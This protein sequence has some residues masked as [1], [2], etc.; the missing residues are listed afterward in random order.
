M[1]KKWTKIVEDLL[2]LAGERLAFVLNDIIEHKRHKE[3]QREG[4]ALPSVKLAV[5]TEPTIPTASSKAKKS[6][7]QSVPSSVVGP[8]SAGSVVGTDR[9]ESDDA[10]LDFAP[11]A[12]QLMVMERRRSRT[13]AAFNLGIAV[14]LVPGLLVALNWH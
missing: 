11:L 5:G 1:G 10:N 2:A 4:R 3:A 7:S 12:R 8:G 6:S 13:E 14:V 9:V